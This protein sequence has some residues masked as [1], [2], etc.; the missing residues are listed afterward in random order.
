M[1]FLFVWGAGI[2]L[3]E[4]FSR[5]LSFERAALHT[6]LR[7]IAYSQT[8]EAKIN[9]STN[10]CALIYCKDTDKI[11][12]A[13]Q[14]VQA[15]LRLDD[16][17]I[18]RSLDGIVDNQLIKFIDSNNCI[19]HLDYLK[20][21]QVDLIMAFPDYSN[22]AKCDQSLK[23]VYKDLKDRGMYSGFGLNIKALTHSGRIIGHIIKRQ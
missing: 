9:Y 6:N 7:K 19:R 16:R 8:E 18:V 21:R 5:N 23:N 14:E 3:Y 10:I 20:Y 15:R 22:G 1:I 13:L 12:V 4:N 2:F 11:I 17:F